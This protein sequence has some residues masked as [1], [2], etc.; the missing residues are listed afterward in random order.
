MI[1][2]DLGNFRQVRG[3]ASIYTGLGLFGIDSRVGL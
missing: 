1:L 3:F 2:D